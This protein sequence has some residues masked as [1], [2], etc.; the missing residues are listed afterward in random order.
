MKAWKHTI[1]RGFID[2]M[3]TLALGV[4]LGVATLV[5]TKEV[6]NPDKSTRPNQ[7]LTA[8][9]KKNLLFNSSKNYYQARQEYE[10][11]VKA[12]DPNVSAKR[13][14]LL[15]A[16]TIYE[17]ATI[18]NTPGAVPIGDVP[19]VPGTETYN[20]TSTLTLTQAS[21]QTCVSTSVSTGLPTTV[22][23]STIIPLPTSNKPPTQTFNQPAT[24]NVVQT[25]TSTRLPSTGEFPTS[26]PGNH[27]PFSDVTVKPGNLGNYT[28]TS[29]GINNTSPKPVF[30]V[31]TNRP[32]PVQSNTSTQSTV[33]TLPN[34]GFEYIKVKAGDTLSDICRRYYGDSGMWVQIVKYQIPSIAAN[35][36]LIFPGQIIALPRGVPLPKPHTTTNPDTKPSS[37]TTYPGEDLPIALPGN[38]SW[39]DRF[40][41][42]FVISDNA[43]TDTN[44]MTIAQIQS[45]LEKH[46]SCLARSYR[47][48]SPAQMIWEASKKFGINP[49]VLLTRLQ[50]EQ[51]LIS[52]TSATDN[53]LDW[54]LG[55]GS[56]DGG[57]WDQNYKGFAKQIEGAAHTYRR[58]YDEGNKILASGKKLTMQI[59]GQTVTLKNASSYAFYQ[60]CPHFHGQKLFLDIWREYKKTF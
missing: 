58:W 29:V 14:Q 30:P 40:Q 6:I 44:T 33:S 36:N 32:R 5:V 55:V 23:T 24:Q 8:E 43:L 26:N 47:G 51:G 11:A 38:E 18:L 20:Q 59:D 15:M 28:A 57:N 48:G 4:A 12:G 16:K 54:A 39:Q 7:N 50:C 45:F 53:Q 3:L 13:E 22:D 60:Y 56:Y 46:H 9:Q 41:T 1:R 52:K 31:N 25:Q 21:T 2:V 27:N 49:Q 35:P 34:A 37:T 10:A 19:P 17:R 42:N